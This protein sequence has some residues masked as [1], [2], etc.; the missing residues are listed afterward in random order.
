MAVVGK[1]KAFKLEGIPELAETLKSIR[2]TLNAEGNIALADRVRDALLVPAQMIADEARDIA[3]RGATGRLRES[4]KAAK[5]KGA[6]AVAFVDRTVAPYAY[7]VEVGTSKM[8]AQPFF[9]PAVAALRPTIARVIA[10]RLPDILADAAE[11]EAWKAPTG[12]G[13]GARGGKA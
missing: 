9:K 8:S 4:I 13:Y 3:P 10:E 2:K 12:K 6:G 7:F 11:Q 1:Q 5:G